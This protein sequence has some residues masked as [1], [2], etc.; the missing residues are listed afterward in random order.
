M[1]NQILNRFLS[2]LRPGAAQQFANL[3]AFPLFAEN[4]QGPAY[5]T[6]A[7]ALAA[8]LLTMKELGEGG[9]VPQLVA[10]N[11]A[12][13]AVLVLDGEEL[14]GAKQNRSL[15]A[16]LLLAPHS[17][18]VIPVSCT[19]AGRWA[20]RSRHFGDSGEF[21]PQQVRARKMASVSQGL[22][23]GR[24]YASD[25]SDVWASIQGLSDGLG[26][27][28]ATSSM[29]EVVEQERA[30]LSECAR[31]FPLQD[32][33]RGLLVAVDGAIR[34]LD[35]VSRPE[36]WA[37]L[38]D[39][40]VRSHALSADTTA[41]TNAPTAPDEASALEF[42]RRAATATL[43][44]RPSVA[45][46]T[47]VR[48]ESNEQLGAGLLHDETIVHLYLLRRDSGHGPHGTGAAFDLSLDRD[49]L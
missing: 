2:G 11:A 25:Q 10:V 18:T 42:L 4:G 7:E 12:D 9:S 13:L 38:H 26:R 49:A 29:R 5:L 8:G 43:T 27:H 17:E 6:L 19:E 45:L 20:S 15:N 31:A 32:G 28:S 3:T 44:T 23:H 34:S 47:D 35:W 46:G 22:K 30:R 21:V 36:A 48:L 39:R 16:T 40:V 33:Q 14:V 37:R 41:G 24:N 1:P